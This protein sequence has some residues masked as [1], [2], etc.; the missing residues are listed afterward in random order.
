M[1]DPEKAEA[2]ARAVRAWERARF[3]QST[4][5]TLHEAEIKLAELARAIPTETP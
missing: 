1:I 5:R 3:G 2:L 4:R